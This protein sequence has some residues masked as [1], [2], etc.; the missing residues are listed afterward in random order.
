MSA[1]DRFGLL[2]EESRLVGGRV[3][4]V[5]AEGLASA[6]GGSIASAVG[7]MSSPAGFIAMVGMVGQGV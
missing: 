4:R 3:Q 2:S 1:F 6:V 5:V 7:A